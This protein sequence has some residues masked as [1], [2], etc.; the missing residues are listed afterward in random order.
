MSAFTLVKSETLAMTSKLAIEVATMPGSDTERVLDERRVD[1][2]RGQVMAGLATP[3]SWAFAIRPDGTIVRSM[4]ST[5]AICCPNSMAICQK[6]SRLSSRLIKLR[7]AMVRSHCFDSSMH[8][9][10][11]AR[12]RMSPALFKASFRNCVNVPRAA[13]KKA[14]EGIAWHTKY[15]VGAP[16]SKGRRC[17]RSV[18]SL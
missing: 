1:Y 2:L 12:L 13:A 7:I 4:A 5:R 3:F 16:V 11:P 9:G 8:G 6:G 10:Q 17:L 18:S 15:I 14:I